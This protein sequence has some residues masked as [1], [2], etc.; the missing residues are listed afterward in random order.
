MN[1]YRF[2]VQ[3]L[4]IQRWRFITKIKKYIL[5]ILKSKKKSTVTFMCRNISLFWV[6]WQNEIFYSHV[7]K[8]IYSDIQ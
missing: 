7:M 1:S 5:K 4:A 3:F 6:G 2:A 8:Q